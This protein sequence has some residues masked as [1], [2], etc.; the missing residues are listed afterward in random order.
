MTSQEKKANHNL[1]LIL[2]AAL[3]TEHALR[4]LPIGS[5]AVKKIIDDRLGV[6]EGER[7]DWEAK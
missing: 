1:N 5:A 7:F 4:F 6:P 2:I 3:A